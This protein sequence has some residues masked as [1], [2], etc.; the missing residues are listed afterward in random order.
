MDS[1]T[2]QRHASGKK[3]PGALGFLSRVPPAGIARRPY[4]AIRQAKITMV[5]PIHARRNA[6]QVIR[7]ARIQVG[8]EFRSI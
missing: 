4:T 6:K 3:S 5:R 2:A 8:G 7:S 1:N